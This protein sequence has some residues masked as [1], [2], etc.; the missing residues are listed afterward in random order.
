MSLLNQQDLLNLKNDITYFDDKYP[1]LSTMILS[2]GMTIVHYSELNSAQKDYAQQYLYFDQVKN[3]PLVVQWDDL[4]ETSLYSSLPM[5][6]IE[7]YTNQDFSSGF[8]EEIPESGT[9]YD[10][11]ASHYNIKGIES[12]LRFDFDLGESTSLEMLHQFG[13]KPCLIK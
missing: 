3:N 10:L 9:I 1:E 6:L 8:V 2:S 5:A 12:I 11:D 4:N 7:W 13:I